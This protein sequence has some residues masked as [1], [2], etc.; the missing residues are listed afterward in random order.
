MKPFEGFDPSGPY[1]AVPNKFFDVLLATF[2]SATEAKLALLFVTR[3]R[4]Y[5]AAWL[6]RQSGQ[7]KGSVNACMQRWAKNGLAERVCVAPDL[8]LRATEGC[9]AG[10]GIEYPL[11]DRHHVLPQSEGGDDNPSNLVDLCPNCH[12]LTHWKPWG[13]TP[14]GLEWLGLEATNDQS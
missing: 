10:C 9:C 1:H 8:N 12:R 4:L 3:P 2:S 14:A 7:S 13:L 6:S 11:M 5:T